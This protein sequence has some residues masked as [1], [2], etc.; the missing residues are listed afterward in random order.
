MPFF[1]PVSITERSAAS[2][3]VTQG[4][5]FGFC[6]HAVDMACPLN[7]LENWAVVQ[8]AIWAAASAWF[9]AEPLLFLT[10]LDHVCPERISLHVPQHSQIMVVRLH[11]NRLEPPLPDT[12]AA[13]V[14][15]MIPPDGRGREPLHPRTHDSNF[16]RPQEEVE[17]SVI[18]QNP[19]R[20]EPDTLHG[21]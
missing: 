10:P 6:F 11:R 5:Q 12:P 19:V 16:M 8:Q 14:V 1:L 21:L 20:P 3:A 2:K 18:R 15:P 17:W 13:A 7:L 4:F 9:Q